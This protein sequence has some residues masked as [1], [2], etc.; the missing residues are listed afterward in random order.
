MSHPEPNTPPGRRDDASPD[1]GPERFVRAYLED[2]NLRLVLL[3][4]AGILVTFSA[5]LLANAIRSKSVAA[6][7]A[8]AVIGVASAEAIRSD[9]VRRGRPGPISGL[10]G[11]AWT[12]VALA[13]WAALHWD[14]F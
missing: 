3:T 14:I 4:G 2:P 1:S 12:L 13:T 11:G 9:F 8:V 10:I 7:L 5:W 6:L